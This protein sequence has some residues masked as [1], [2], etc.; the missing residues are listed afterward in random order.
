VEDYEAAQLR[1]LKAGLLAAGLLALGSLAFTGE[2]P[3]KRPKPRQKR[4]HPALS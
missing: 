2:L 1:S 4:A 3:S